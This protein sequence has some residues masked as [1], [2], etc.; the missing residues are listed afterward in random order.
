MAKEIVDITYF[1][2]NKKLSLVTNINKTKILK[3]FRFWRIFKKMFLIVKKKK[4]FVRLSS[5]YN[6][7]RILHHQFQSI[8]GINLKKI[9]F[10]PTC[11]YGFNYHFFDFW[12]NI[13]SIL[14]IILLR[15]KFFSK[16]VEC[17][18]SIKRKQVSLNG[19]IVLFCK[20]IVVE[21]S[22]I[23]KCRFKLVDKNIRFIKYSWRR[24]RWKKSKYILSKNYKK[25]YISV[26]V[27]S[28][29]G[30]ILNYLHVNY[31]IYSLIFIKKPVFQESLLN[32]N[33]RMLDISHFKFLYNL[34]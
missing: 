23:Q 25:R 22:L 4:F 34:I 27:L 17:V 3:K 7:K 15:V 19:N 33:T 14:C 32:F 11:K 1:K 5:L 13:E 28:R 20:R 8:F 6:Y 29:K 21:N 12:S 9:A 26:F 16:I 24:D 30:I 31:N 2:K 18:S 10:I